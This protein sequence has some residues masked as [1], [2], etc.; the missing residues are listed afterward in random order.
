MGNK[1]ADAKN[2][3]TSKNLDDSR[4]RNL[5]GGTY[6]LRW[7]QK[8]WPRDE[9]NA[10]ITDGDPAGFNVVLQNT[11][12]GMFYGVQNVDPSQLQDA[13]P[14]LVDSTLVDTPWDLPFT[15]GTSS[16]P[17]SLVN[18]PPVQHYGNYG[19]YQ[20]DDW[21]TGYPTHY[22]SHEAWRRQY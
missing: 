8:V 12:S 4:V 6:S 17:G 22:P 21:Q 13:T 11:K 16:D 18:A 3:F 10:E 19:P 20:D 14:F 7:L 9:N 2:V 1:A 15:Y 5:P